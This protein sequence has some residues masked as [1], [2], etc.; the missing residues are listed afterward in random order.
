MGIVPYRQSIGTLQCRRQVQHARRFPLK[1]HWLDYARSVQGHSTILRSHPKIR[2]C[3]VHDQNEASRLFRTKSKAQWAS[4]IPL[5][6]SAAFVYLSFFSRFCEQRVVESKPKRC[7]ILVKELDTIESLQTNT[8]NCVC[9]S[10][11]W[12][13]WRLAKTAKNW[14]GRKG[15]GALPPFAIYWR[16]A[17]VDVLTRLMVALQCHAD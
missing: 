11:R 8:G 6:N 9:R 13:T 2:S 15:L 16:L 3:L 7:W 5:V 10:T 12:R 17:S 4:L 1:G 14:A